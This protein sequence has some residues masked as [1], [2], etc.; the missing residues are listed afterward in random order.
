MYTRYLLNVKDVGR[1]SEV[2]LL[3]INLLTQLIDV[4]MGFHSFKLK[5]PYIYYCLGRPCSSNRNVK[6]EIVLF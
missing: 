3:L 4:T 5:L 2:N 1:N 6:F